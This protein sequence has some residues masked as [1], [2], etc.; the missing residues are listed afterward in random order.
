MQAAP[1]TQAVPN[2]AT[3]IA[4]AAKRLNDLRENW[5]NPPEWPP[6]TGVESAAFGIK[7]LSYK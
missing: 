3:A 7:L 5:R 2:N 6:P 1:A 4:T